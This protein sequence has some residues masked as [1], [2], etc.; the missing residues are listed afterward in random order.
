MA[1]PGKYELREDLTVNEA[2]AIAGGSLK[3][4]RHSEVVL[5]RR[6]SG[7][8]AETHVLDLRKM[9]G[10]RNLREDMHLHPGDSIF[11][12]ESKISK[13]GRFVPTNSM[14]WYMNP[15]EYQGTGDTDF[16]NCTSSDGD[17]PDTHPD[18][19]NLS[20]DLN[21]QAVFLHVRRRRAIWPRLYSGVRASC[22]RC[23]GC[24]CWPPCW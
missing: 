16:T 18:R 10:S 22:L 13:I 17:F 21:H 24:C 7:D 14:S 6:V 12:P 23:L 19:M 4:A 1:K 9:L 15:L 2:V 8:V 11:V 5:F 3:M 20:H